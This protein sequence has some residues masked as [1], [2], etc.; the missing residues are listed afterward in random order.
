ME[1]AVFSSEQVYAPFFLADSKLYLNKYPFKC[2]PQSILKGED[3]N[4]CED[5]GDA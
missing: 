4:Y 5:A 1:N 2:S 3:V